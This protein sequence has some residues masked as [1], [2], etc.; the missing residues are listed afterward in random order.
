M[1][2]LPPTFNRFADM[3][4]SPNAF[5]R[6]YFMADRTGCSSWNAGIDTKELMDHPL[7][8]RILNGRWLMTIPSFC[9]RCLLIHRV[10]FIWLCVSSDALAE[11]LL[12]ARE[13]SLIVA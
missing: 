8:S 4:F 12:A 9:G 2:Q 13:A 5:P 3:R 6:P 10:R 1:L 11:C 7:E